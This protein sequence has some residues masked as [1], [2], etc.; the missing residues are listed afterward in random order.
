M[1]TPSDFSSSIEPHILYEI[2]KFERRM[3]WGRGTTR[4][5]RRNGMQ[6]R[7]CGRKLYVLGQHA[8]DYVVRHGKRER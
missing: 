6:V 2:G 5:A 1:A 3:G 8:I 4:Q 7:Y